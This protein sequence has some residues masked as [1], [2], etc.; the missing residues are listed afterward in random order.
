MTLFV[1]TRSWP[2]VR[3]TMPEQVPDAEA[4]AHVEQLQA[5]YA[6]DEPF[7]L[8]M[9]GAELPRHSPAF[10]QAY[11]AW[12]MAS[13]DVQRRLCRG[14]VRIEPDA[15][16]R[17]AYRERAAAAARANPQPYAYA[18]V[19]DEVEAAELAGRWLASAP[20]P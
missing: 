6:L 18:I 13:M 9:A 3:L 8:F 2:I 7:V 4:Q 1:D 19:A 10:M 16:L 17:A 11:G 20:Q 12:A 14:A 5:V 15:G